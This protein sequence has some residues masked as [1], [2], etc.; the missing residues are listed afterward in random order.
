MD[1]FVTALVSGALGGALGAG[2]TLL[3]RRAARADEH[4][5]WLRETS[6]QV[7]AQLLEEIRRAEALVDSSDEAARIEQEDRMKRALDQVK[8]LGALDVAERFGD[9]FAIFMWHRMPERP[10]G[11]DPASGIDRAADDVMK[12]IRNDL[13]SNIG[14]RGVESL[15]LGRTRRRFPRRRP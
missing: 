14:G 2:A 4:R 15:G 5:R 1:A 12:A 8:I 11:V 13:A 6:R 10:E 9:V 7:Y 3:D